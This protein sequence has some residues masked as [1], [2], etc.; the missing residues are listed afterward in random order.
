MSMDILSGLFLGAGFVAACWIIR[1]IWMLTIGLAIE[2]L[3][4]GAP[5]RRRRFEER[6]KR[7]GKVAA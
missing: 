1:I 7:T 6:S 5:R 4:A 2:T 3:I